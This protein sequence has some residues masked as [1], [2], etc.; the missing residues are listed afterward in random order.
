VV[1]VSNSDAHSLDNL[2][3]EANVLRRGDGVTYQR[4]C[5]VLRGQEP[6]GFSYTIEFYPEEG[7]YHLDGHSPCGVRLTPEETARAGGRCPSCRKPV[8]VGVLSRV[9]A[10]ADRPAA[11]PAGRVPFK[12]IVPLREL[13]AETLGVGKQAKQVER[14]YRAIV[15]ALGTEF[16]LLLHTPVEAIA[17]A[18][19]ALVATAVGRVRRGEVHIAAGYDGTF[20]TVRVFQPGEPRGPAQTAL[21]G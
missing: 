3:R 8:T 6:G 4:L 16:E 19:F 10:L 12:S 14:T 11:D 5:R 21:F 2:G 13:I 1:L 7:K 17:A 15:P 18:G 20:G 9:S